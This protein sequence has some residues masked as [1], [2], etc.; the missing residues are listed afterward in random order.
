[1]KNIYE[2]LIPIIPINLLCYWSDSTIASSWIKNT[3]KKCELYIDRRVSEIRK[4]PNPLNWHHVISGSN[5]AYILSRGRLISEIS[6]LDFWFCGPKFLCT[7][8]QFDGVG[9][10]T[11]FVDYAYGSSQFCLLA[12]WEECSREL[13]PSNC[14]NKIDLQFLNIDTFSNYKRLLNITALVLKFINNLQKS[15]NQEKKVVQRH[16]TTNKY[17]KAEH[18]WLVFI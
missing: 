3:S 8:F 18:L 4:L 11:C 1:M 16:V 10:N 9:Q 13:C 14:N 7:K 2:S 15:L 5:P 17:S 12:R 6:K